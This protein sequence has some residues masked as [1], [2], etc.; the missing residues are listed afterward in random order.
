MMSS[1]KIC[2]KNKLTTEKGNSDKNLIF[3]III[4]TC[5]FFP[6][7]RTCV[8]IVTNRSNMSAQ[9]D[10][11]AKLSRLH[12]GSWVHLHYPHSQVKIMLS[13]YLLKGLVFNTLSITYNTCIPQTYQM[14]LTK[15]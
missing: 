5:T 13:I 10:K 7:K 11:K 2:K 9:Q 1:I 6:C 12:P 15:I 14:L 8:T 4:I 3:L